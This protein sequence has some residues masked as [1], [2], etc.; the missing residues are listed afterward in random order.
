MTAG[1]AGNET[2][3]LADG[4][5]AV[6]GMA[7]RFPGAPDIDAYWANILAGRDCLTD[8]TTGQ[9]RAAGVDP[10][11][12]EDPAYVP[13][14][15]LLDDI[16]R[17]DATLFGYSAREA[18]IMDP[19]Q[20][21]FLQTCW[22]ALEHAGR[23]DPD[24]A[25]ASVGVFAGA[26]GVL[27]G[28]LPGLLAGARPQDTTASLEHLGNDK[29][30]LTTRVSYK[31][32]LTGPSLA[33][34]TACSTSLVAVHLAVQSLLAG[35]CATALAGGVTVRVPAEQGYLHRD[36]S[37]LA[38]DGRC[39]PFD[40][41]A[42]G[43]VFG[44]GVGAVVLRPLADALR[45]GDTVYAVLRGTAVTNDGGGKT[46][47]GASSE[48]GQ[49]AAMREAIAV[50]GVDPATIG[51]AEAH[52]TGTFLGDPLEFAALGKAVGPGARC[53][54]GS[55][56]ALI[57]HTEAAAGVAGLIKAVL[58][59]HHAT[60]PGS[61]H[62]RTPNPR[63]RIDDSALYL[64][65]APEPWTAPV[66]RAVVNS[67][68]IGGTNAFA[69]L[70]QAPPAPPAP[71]ALP[72][73]TISLSARTPEGLLETVGRWADAL[74]ATDGPALADLAHTSHVGRRRLPHRVTVVAESPATAAARL[75]QWR[76]QGQAPDV[77]AAGQVA[78]RP[79]VA[80]LFS[81]QG[82][83]YPAMAQD[84]YQRHPTFREL[85]D[86]DA[87]TY[88]DLTGVPLADVLFDPDRSAGLLR[89]AELLQPAMFLLETALC[90][91][92]AVWGVRPAAVAGH[93][94]G[95]YAAAHA[96][97]IISRADGLRLVAERGRII[98]GLP[99]GGR[100]LVV[101]CPDE[102][103]LHHLVAPYVT[104]LAVAGYNSPDR[105][106]ISGAADAVDAVRDACARHR[107]ATVPLDTTHAFH[108]PLVADAAVPLAAAARDVTHHEPSLPLAT[109][110]TGRYAEPG[111]V[112]PG[113][114][115][116][117]LLAPVRFREAI[118]TL[119]ADGFDR[120]V[121]V[122]PGNGLAAL[123]RTQTPGRPG[124]WLPTLLPRA[125][126]TATV[127]HTLTQLDLAG[128]PVDWAAF[129]RPLRRRRVAAPT[130]PFARDRHWA[131]A[132]PSGDGPARPATPA[133]RPLALPHSSERR[134]ETTIAA[135]SPRILPDH[136]IHG[137]VIVPGAYLLACLAE[138]TGAPV[139]ADDV[140]FPEP[141]APAEAAA[142]VQVVL[143]PATGGGHDATVLGLHPGDDPHIDRAW[144]VHAEARLRTPT[145]EDVSG[146]AVT[147]DAAS[148]AGA[149]E[150]GDDVYD[151]LAARGLR[152][153]PA[154]R[155]IVRMRRHGDTAEAELRRPAAL[156]PDSRP[157]RAV[158]IDS[159]IQ[160]AIAA[161][162][163]GD[164][165][166]LPFRID[167][168]ELDPHVT[169]PDDAVV[170]VRLRPPAGSARF[171]A[172]VLVTAPGGT[173]PVRLTGL[174]LRRVTGDFT[175]RARPV[176]V[177]HQS[178]EPRPGGYS[179]STPAGRWVVVTDR[180][181]VGHDIAERLR[182][183]GA[184]VT[185]A[186]PGDLS[187]LAGATGV[188]YC[189]ALDLTV[190]DTATTPPAA[191]T[192]LAA[193]VAAAP[194]VERCAVLTAGA[195]AVHGPA[196][197]VRPLASA[198]WGLARTAALEAPELGVQLIDLDPADLAGSVARLPGLLTGSAGENAIRA[199]VTFRPLLVVAPDP[200]VPLRAAGD[201]TY[202]ITGGLGALGRHLARRLAAA[203]AGRLI[204]CGRRTG[205]AEVAALAADLTAAG[206]PTRI[207]ALD[208]TDGPAVH[209]L[210]AGLR[211]ERLRGVFH[212]AGVVEDAVLSR[213]TPEAFE[214]VLAPKVTGAWHLHEAT[215]G[216]DLDHFV[217]ASSTAGLL[218]SAGQGHYAAANTFL[219]GLAHHR[220][221]LGL[222]ALS[223]D[224]GPLDD[225]M[226]ARMPAL[227]R[228]RLTANG[229]TPAGLDAVVTALGT[230][231]SSGVAQA[232]LAVVDWPAYLARLPHGA[233][234]DNVPA[235]VRATAAADTAALDRLLAGDPAHRPA[236][237]RAYLATVV[238]ERL[239][240]P[241]VDLDPDADL[242][243]YGLDS[244]LAIEI[245][246]R[247]R[248][249]TGYVLQLQQ[250]IDGARLGPLGDSLAAGLAPA[251]PAAAPPPDA[252]ATPPDAAAAAGIT[253]ELTPEAAAELLA[254]G[255]DDAD[256]DALEALL[257]A[258]GLEA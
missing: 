75:R 160:A 207:V 86:R 6:V 15:A 120:F 45:D 253:G 84:L 167:Q 151:R 5:I 170:T 177:H 239:G 196:D 19:Q 130:Y 34:Q 227:H 197:V 251:G 107:W 157:A 43:T 231:M 9:L 11:L 63:L 212:L 47:Y 68:G 33:V 165:L 208:V 93:S 194:H 168:A 191:L 38:P 172:D 102:Q 71:A 240:M 59:L 135:D 223:A 201:G 241:A 73:E 14:A 83:Q 249:D 164:G 100:M 70:E 46:S 112:G 29:D 187:G 222:P 116:R 40:A 232:C 18:A 244:M 17:F 66:R 142:P 180:G 169:V 89:R 254:A 13:S 77:R 174:E 104:D 156:D 137:R 153:G 25:P 67:L 23:L 94:L 69:V 50:S 237:A 163:D 245:R 37:I 114:W 1:A 220:R 65:S 10:A 161:G 216:L 7:G 111:E 20:R 12:I 145:A 35:E 213:L 246:A 188:V 36:G 62:V 76:D 147:P 143:R 200:A 214:R 8:L 219:D 175:G 48:S 103:A 209:A 55:V 203:G 211:G 198:I 218:G 256:L 81:G 217:T 132:G 61:P 49:L 243:G 144:H 85:I 202:L 236:Q 195:V 192:G 250:L 95:E 173:R 4:R 235:G 134:W 91:L 16:D 225:G 133:L 123:G 221:G 118:A 242:A 51:Y 131:Q 74:T 252:A 176:P 28:Y 140:I 128:V 79:K 228:D 136:V 3:A 138:T 124:A 80:F 106:L 98:A 205:S 127:Q 54:I 41:A 206:T 24:A 57:G 117:Q 110:L 87:A 108:S 189:P 226:A 22:T 30:F 27:A 119:L 44:S 154:F 229:F 82:S 193:L 109:I 183:G 158:L 248:T 179:P 215:R 90:D 238:A 39:R 181:G 141:L 150:T 96:A 31:L 121:E 42:A 185:E 210:I 139:I 58:A 182:A 159:C 146:H 52:G 166:Y 60:I 97:S 101:A 186:E 178:W 115:P 126:D 155:W 247:V 129:H 230:A 64:P 92:W 72:V 78:A 199:G 26:G 162:P 148:A 32:N 257:D 171:V 53:A 224:L 105:Y 152:L 204:L 233:L 56:K 190:P 99:T 258:S 21:L 2:P 149:F 125:A 122:G 255:V 113:Y 234:T 184:T 88:A